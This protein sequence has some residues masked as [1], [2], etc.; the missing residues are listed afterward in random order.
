MAKNKIQIYRILH[1]K[2]NLK[3]GKFL[4]YVNTAD[5]RHNIIT[6]EMDWLA[7]MVI[8]ERIDV[9]LFIYL[10]RKFKLL[11][12]KY[13]AYLKVIKNYGSKEHEI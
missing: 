1:P 13:P 10:F 8:Y 11:Q 4:G 7:K 2:I 12:H 9:E 5:I 3:L 6:M